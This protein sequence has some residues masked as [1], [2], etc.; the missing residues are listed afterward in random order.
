MPAPAALDALREALPF[1]VDDRVGI[2]HHVEVVPREA[3]APDFFHVAARAGNT[4]AFVRQANFANAGG[5]STDRR[6][7][8]AKAVGE[9][10]E[11]YCAAVFEVDELPLACRADA[12][13]S[14]VAPGEFGLHSRAQYETP[15]FPWVPFDENTPVR[16]MAGIDLTRDERVHVPAAM[17][18]M[19]YHFYRGTGDA[20]IGQPISTGLACH[21]SRARAAIAG[22]C[23]VIERDAFTLMWQAA[24]PRAQLRVET[25]GDAA[26]DLVERFE[27][28]GSTVVLLDITTDIGVPTVLA[29]LQSE[30]PAAPALVF[31]AA[32]DPDPDV[33][34]RKSLEELAHTRRYSQQ[35]KSRL[36]R[37]AADPAHGNVVD[38]VDHLNFWCDHAHRPLADFVFA[39]HE[40]I[41]FDELPTLATGEPARD[42]E[43]LVARVREA[44][45]RVVLCDLETPDVGDLGL[46]VV[47]VV[48]PGLHPLFMGYRLRALG[49]TR[50]WTVPQR[51]GFRGILPE[52]GDNPVP[53]PYP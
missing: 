36:P 19:P 18:F 29:V 32:A 31:A 35:V 25:L 17:V 15:G 11:R 26:Y 39:S 8:V 10:V 30:A 1:L 44:G 23:E 6:V 43:T 34:V 33:A 47:R 41:D 51:L 7:A 14:C 49:G 37:L 27:R 2:V 3:G 5:A 22:L 52:T 20:P 38:Q 4:Q 46:H 24:L 9:A 53:H 12:P 42:L 28:T 40:R 48:V 45:H 50:L 16:W 21:V 13:F